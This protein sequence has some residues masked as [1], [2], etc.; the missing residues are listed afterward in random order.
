MERMGQ[1]MNGTMQFRE[2]ES[3]KVLVEKI[4]EKL[5]ARDYGAVLDTLA[6]F[7]EL[8][9]CNPEAF[10]AGAY[11]YFMEGDY[12]RS[13]QWVNNTLTCDSGHVAARILLSRLCI[14]EDRTVE[15][16]S[17]LDALLE[18]GKGI[19]AE[20]EL[21]EIREIAGYY[22]RTKKEMVCR[23]YPH[24]AEFLQLSGN[25]ERAFDRIKTEGRVSAEP[26]AREEYA[27]LL[28]RR[29]VSEVEAVN[30][31]VEEKVRVL[32]SFA[33]AWYAEGELGAAKVLLNAALRMDS[34]SQAA[35]KGMAMV[36]AETG[37]TDKAMQYAAY[38]Q[39][40]DFLL[41]RT[42]REGQKKK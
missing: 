15:A 7:A 26:A 22:G 32:C 2:R 40:T 4:R 10:Y 28:A 21:G 25:G 1:K 24:I 38:V 35:L 5:D 20:E 37:N 30:R 29:K 14:L 6:K 18:K 11:A 39:P 9:I 13:A 27:E 19:L 33:G 36:E 16:L 34:G 23:E 12:Q 41:L 8:G 31:S 17:V 42:I 3:E